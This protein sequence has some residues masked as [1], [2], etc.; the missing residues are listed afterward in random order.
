MLSLAG[1]FVFV[2]IVLN[3]MLVYMVIRPVTRLAKLADQASLGNTDVP[4]STCDRET[5]SACSRTRSTA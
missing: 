1:V 2:A 5:R 4:D 3:V